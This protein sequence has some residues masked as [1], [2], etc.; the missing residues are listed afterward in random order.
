MVPRS[1]RQRL[2]AGSGKRRSIVL[3]SVGAV[4]LMLATA[5]AVQQQRPTPVTPPVFVLLAFADP[6]VPVPVLEAPRE[7]VPPAV[8]EAL[9]S[10]APEPPEL[11]V[12]V[13]ASPA[14][15]AAAGKCTPVDAVQAALAAVPEVQ[16]ALAAVPTTKRSVADAIVVWNSDWSPLAA[17]ID[18]PLASVREV[19]TNT[20]KVLPSGCLAETVNGPRLVLVNAAGMTM[21]LAFGSG[22]WRWQDL[23]PGS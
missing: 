20:L 22:S 14:M 2:P 8:A 7:V 17:D 23:A 1:A 5:L 10:V 21:V 9:S 16:R 15:E 13:A 12:A 6:H 18:A 11:A 19:V 3:M 4:H